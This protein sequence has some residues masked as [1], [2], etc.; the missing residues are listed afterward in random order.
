MSFI[1]F[2][3]YEVSALRFYKKTSTVSIIS[4]QPSYMWTWRRTNRFVKCI[5]IIHELN[6]GVA[7]VP[8]LCLLSVFW[9]NLVQMLPKKRGWGNYAQ[10]LTLP[11][12]CNK[13]QRPECIFIKVAQMLKI[14]W[15]EEL[16]G[17]L[18]SYIVGQ[19]V[20][21]KVINCYKWW[22]CRDATICLGLAFW[23]HTHQ[24]TTG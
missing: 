4:E 2:L 16:L 22:V 9:S 10:M 15:V 14:W 21:D 19:K 13:K 20:I 6:C 12:E 24:G 8:C 5:F 3:N 17:I 11:C 1:A 7:V 23:T 18:R